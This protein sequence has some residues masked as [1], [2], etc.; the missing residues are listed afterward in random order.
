MI[1]DYGYMILKFSILSVFLLIRYEK[2]MELSH[3][4]VALILFQAFRL[5]SIL[6]LLLLNIIIIIIIFSTIWKSK[7][8]S[9]R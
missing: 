5:I 4:I 6:K 7:K 9:L 3:R 8:K 2:R 1:R